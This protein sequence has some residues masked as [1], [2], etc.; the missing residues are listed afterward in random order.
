M[1]TPLYVVAYDISDHRL[2]ARVARCLEGAGVRVQESVFECRLRDAEMRAVVRRLRADL[3]EGDGLRVY[4]LGLSGD[5]R[6]ERIGGP[7]VPQ[8]ERVLFA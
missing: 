4:A 5:A 2:R 6:V 8:D 3:R 1:P 7:P